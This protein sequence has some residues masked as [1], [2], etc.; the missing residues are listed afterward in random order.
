MTG[1]ELHERR[2]FVQISAV[3]RGVEHDLDAESD[4][5]LQISLPHGVE[6]GFA[7]ET[8]TPLGGVDVKGDTTQAG[9]RKTGQQ[10]A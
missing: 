3:D 9:A 7:G 1:K 8:V 4:R 2:D 6:R 5:P 10:S